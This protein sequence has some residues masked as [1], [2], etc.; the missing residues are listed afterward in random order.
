M[1]QIFLCDFSQHYMMGDSYAMVRFTPKQFEELLTM[2]KE[3]E[4]DDDKYDDL[5]EKIALIE[6]EQKV[7]LFGLENV[8]YSEMFGKK[9]PKAVISI[10]KQGKN[11]SGEWEEGSFAFAT[12]HKKA[13][14]AVMKIEAKHVSDGWF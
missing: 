1:R 12:T 9:S 2:K 3:A 8:P 4:T 10:L 7:Q 11:V 14:T 13:Q 5:S 6:K